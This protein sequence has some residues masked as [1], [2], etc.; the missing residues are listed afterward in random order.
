MKI[1]SAL[2]AAAI[3]AA[4]IMVAP[5][6]AN[7]ASSN[8]NMAFEIDQNAVSWTLSDNG[9]VKVTYA[10]LY[11]YGTTY[12]DAG[13]VVDLGQAESFAGL[14]VE[15]TGPWV[16]NIWLGDGPEAYTPGTYYLSD[17]VD[18]SYGPWTDPPSTFWTGPQSTACG[19]SPC[20]VSTAQIDSVGPTEVYAWIGVVYDGNQVSANITSV[21]GH[22]V[23]NRTVS[24]T[25]NPHGTVTA[26]VK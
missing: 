3:G 24:F 7:A 1:A 20:P 9:T 17:P 15:A 2:M 6:D 18:F 16:A 11:A 8:S 19:G 14:N 4:A 23:G 25:N 12:S 22:S 5:L 21:N 10:P 13:I 26:T